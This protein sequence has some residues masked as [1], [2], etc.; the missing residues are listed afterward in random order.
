MQISVD[1]HSFAEPSNDYLE[2]SNLRLNQDIL[3]FAKENVADVWSD[4][5]TRSANASS[6]NMMQVTR[7]PQLPSPFNTNNKPAQ[8]PVLVN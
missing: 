3:R 1:Y 4:R 2:K 5:V 6:D 7:S 8:C